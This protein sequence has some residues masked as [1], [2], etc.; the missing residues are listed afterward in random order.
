MPIHDWTR[1]SAGDFHDFHQVW[2]AQIRIQLNSGVLPA[3]YYAQV[4]QQASGIIPDVLSLHYGAEP[5]NESGAE[6]FGAALA[7]ATTPP[8]VQFI[9]EVEK[10]LYAD[11]N[12]RVNIHH[13]SDRRIVAIIELVSAGNK[14]SE[15]E[16]KRFLEKAIAAITQGVHLLIVDLQPPTRRDPQ[17]IHG[18]IWSELEDDEYRAPADKPLTLVAYSAG[19]IPKAYIEPVAVGQ[20]LTA[21]PLFLSE[22]R[23]ISAPLEET[24]TATFNSSPPHVRHALT[25]KL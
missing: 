10:R 1:V 11:L 20:R 17:G 18:A 8:R 21:M 22:A 23:Y 16:L 2:A 12:N 13:V 24:Y 4:E 19:K 7:V 3:G 15:G 6:D 9:A 14:S 25:Q 5:P